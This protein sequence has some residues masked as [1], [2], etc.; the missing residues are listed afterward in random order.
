R[1]VKS[2]RTSLVD[3]GIAIPLFNLL[4]DES[5]AVQTTASATLCNIVLD[6]SP[7]KKTVLENGG[8]ERLVGLVSSMDANLRL[9][10]V[11]A[12]KNLLFQADSEI[13]QTVMRQLKYSQLISLIDDSD[14][15]IQEQA[16]N[17]LRNLACGKESV[18]LDSRPLHVCRRFLLNFSFAFGWHG[19]DIEEVFEGIGEEKLMRIL[20][21]K[22][23][24]SSEE[25]ILQTLYV[26]VN[27]ATGNERHKMGI[28]HNENLLQ[29]VY[30]FMRTSGSRPYGSQ[31]HLRRL[32]QMGFEDK[33]KSM[34]ED[35]D[36]DVRDRVKTALGHFAPENVGNSGGSGHNSGSVRS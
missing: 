23:R 24:S 16:L 18:S 21:Y 8:V 33:L 3:A 5:I 9:N 17:L 22:L 15:G 30:S 11:W 26:I 29:S 36:L 13:K 28:M 25:I 31:D 1:S 7:M 34:A 4:G 27:I 12:L 10:S 14:M 6:F 2:L 19:Q 35:P 32:G 20:E